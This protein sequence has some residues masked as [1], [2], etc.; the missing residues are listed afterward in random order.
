MIQEVD[1]FPG[2]SDVIPEWNQPAPI[3][4]KQLLSVPVGRGY[5]GFAHPQRVGECAGNNLRFIQVR[6]DINICRTDK[7]QQVFV[8][9]ETVV[10]NNVVRDTEFFCT[11]MQ[12]D[13]VILSLFRLVV[14]MGCTYHHIDDLRVGFHNLRQSIDHHFNALARRKQTEGQDYLFSG[15]V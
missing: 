6:G 11:H 1:D 4:G 14:W 13:S 10:K 7:L 15:Y 3:I 9:D 8:G 2:Q 5:H 12:A